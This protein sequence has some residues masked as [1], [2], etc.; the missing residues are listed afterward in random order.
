MNTA[1]TGNDFK[2]SAALECFLI[3]QNPGNLETV[4]NLKYLIFKSPS[5]NLV[6]A[7]NFSKLN[8]FLKEVEKQ[9]ITHFQLYA[10]YLVGG[11]RRDR[12]FKSHMTC[13]ARSNLMIYITNLKCL[14]PYLFV[15]LYLQINL[16][17]AI[18]I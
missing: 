4:N 3:T 14:S 11:V 10:D 8:L 9:F 12:W 7:I 5:Q 16:Y 17:V 1:R 18:Y 13:L 6:L 2:I 15:Y